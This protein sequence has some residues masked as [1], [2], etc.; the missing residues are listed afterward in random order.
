MKSNIL[1]AESSRMALAWAYL[2]QREVNGLLPNQRVDE[3]HESY[4]YQVIVSRKKFFFRENCILSISKNYLSQIL[5]PPPPRF[6]WRHAEI[7]SHS[8]L[9]LL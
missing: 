2:L 6:I 5:P 9:L 7:R 8:S 1:N 4:I 3:K